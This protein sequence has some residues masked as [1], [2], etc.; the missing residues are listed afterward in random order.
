MDS[1]VLV[2]LYV[3]EP[4]SEAAAAV[5]EQQPVLTL[6]GL[7]EL[8][9]RNTFRVLEA[10]KILTAAQRAAAEHFLELDCVEGRLHRTAV[11]W[12]AV[13]QHSIDLSRTFTAQTLA[14]SLDILHV[15]VAIHHQCALFITADNRQASFARCCGLRVEELA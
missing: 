2:K 8:E 15:A 13:F 1:G 4:N 5:I 14:R 11:D 10:R 3:R 7:L 6:N 12:T 9:I